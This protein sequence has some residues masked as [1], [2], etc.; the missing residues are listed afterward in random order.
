MIGEVSYWGQGFA[1]EAIIST[2]KYSFRTLGLKKLMA[3]CHIDNIASKK[4]FINSG[5]KIEGKFKKD[6][7]LNGKMVDTLWLGRIINE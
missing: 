1:T 7:I 3:S 4:I 6:A 5:F 2:T